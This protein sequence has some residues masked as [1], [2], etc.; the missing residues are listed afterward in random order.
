MTNRNA[1]DAIIIGAGPNGLLAGAYL[2]KAGHKVLIC[3]RRHET[4]G[5]LNTEEYFGFRLNLHAIYHMMAEKMPAYRDLDLPAL[6]LRYIHPQVVAAFPFKDGSSLI[7]TRDPEET[8]QSIAQLSPAD[9]NAFRAMWEEFQPLLDDYLIPMTYEL[10]NP[11]LDQLV[12]FQQTPTG[13]RL[14]EI[15]ELSMVELM[16]EYGFEN[17]QVRLALLSFA[18]MW[19]IHLDEPLG[20]LYPLYLCRMMDGALVK[21]GSHRLSSAMYRSFLKTGGTVI[22]EYAVTQ[23]LTEDGQAVGVRLE[24]GREF[25]ADAVIST[26]NPEQTF[27]QLLSADTVPADLAASV[28]RWEWEDRSLF[29]LH[30]GIAGKVT[31]KAADPRVNEAM[32][33]FCGLE[34]E[35]DL[36]EHLQRVDAGDHARPEWMH[37]TLPT[38][39]DASMAPPGHTVLRAEAVVSYDEQWRDQAP[40]FGDECLALLKRYADIDGEVVLRREITPVDIEQKLTTMKFG[41]FK[42]GAYTSLQMGYLRPNE[43]CSRCETPIDGLFLGGASMYPGGMVLGA[44]G[45]LAA[46]VVGEFLGSAATN[47]EEPR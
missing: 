19:G 17:S 33:V 5:G 31:Y 23:I 40:A 36:H 1:Y 7:F 44:C 42:H 2:A 46:N 39:H 27:Q 8:A 24:D 18:A 37:V 35:D 34:S 29:G 32:I 21:G 13:N 47:D 9:A 30:L 6:G 15:S 12:E 4:G 10:P 3:E 45:Y 38:T 26:L 20:F 41:S 22:D 16:D 43:E 11:A 14:A 25:R 28:E